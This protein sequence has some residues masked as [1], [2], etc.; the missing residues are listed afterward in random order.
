M[1]KLW[2]LFLVVIF[3]PCQIAYGQFSVVAPVLET[4]MELSYI[5]QAVSFAQMLKDNIEQ[6]QHLKSQ[7]EN[8]AR[9]VE[10]AAKNWSHI[11]DIKSFDDFM[12]WYNRQLYL[13]KKTEDAFT[14]MNV[15]IG[16]KNYSL[17]DIEGIGHGL[18][19]TYI[20]YWDKEFTE[21]QRKEMWVGLGLTPSNYVYVQ[22]WK[23]RER[24]LARQFL[25]R[26]TVQNDE[27]MD[28]MSRAD[29]I[30]KHLAEDN[31]RDDDEK[32]GE[33]EL[34]AL[35]VELLVMNNKALNNLLM[36]QAEQME[37]QAVEKYQ[38]QTSPSVDAPVYSDWPEDGFRQLR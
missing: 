33:K 25:T 27:Y 30:L 26:T 20:D 32:I 5:E 35:Q 29:E 17:W 12:D 38:T 11:G 22:T 18:Q 31:A 37:W 23:Q 36:M 10:M 16:K 15:T 19:E 14:G 1:K 6:I 34:Q 21:E 2:I 28:D 9:S 13:E 4:F 3:M 7:A 24:E 8:M